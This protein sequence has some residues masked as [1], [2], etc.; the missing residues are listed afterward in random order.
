MSI[1]KTR[2]YRDIDCALS[3]AAINP[4]P[5]KARTSPDNKGEDDLVF[6]ITITNDKDKETERSA[7]I[8]LDKKQLRQLNKLIDDYLKTGIT[9]EN[10]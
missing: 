3:I 4:P 5:Q 10:G 7:Y 1:F 8:E 9:K 2:G 6:H